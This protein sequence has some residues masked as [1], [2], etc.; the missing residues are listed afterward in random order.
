MVLHCMTVKGLY[1]R[2]FVDAHQNR[3]LW[4]DKACP[5]CTWLITS[6]NAQNHYRCNSLDHV[7]HRE[8]ITVMSLSSVLL[9]LLLS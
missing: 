3:L 4:T 6:R 2:P 1:K 7:D 8:H 9:L 5:A